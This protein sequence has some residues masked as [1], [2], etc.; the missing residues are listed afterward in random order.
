MDDFERF[1]QESASGAS[2]TSA[3][4]SF[5]FL[6]IISRRKWWIITGLTLG[7][8]IGFLIFQN[9]EPAFVSL[10]RLTVLR[11]G[12]IDGPN[13]GGSAVDYQPVRSTDLELEAVKLSSRKSSSKPFFPSGWK[14]SPAWRSSTKI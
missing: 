4:T 10:G 3:S 5:D 6:G 11:R 9:S 7:T 1:Q 12:G 8:F 13:R 14:N 2:T